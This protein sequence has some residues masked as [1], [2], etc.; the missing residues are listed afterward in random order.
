VNE[1]GMRSRGECMEKTDSR[2]VNGHP[3]GFLNNPDE[4][5]YQRVLK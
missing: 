5:R 1:K 4:R 2:T 3:S